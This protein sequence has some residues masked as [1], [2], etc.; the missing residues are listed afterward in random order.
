M[1][2]K[3]VAENWSNLFRILHLTAWRDVRNRPIVDFP[4]NE[5]HRH[6]SNIE[7]QHEIHTSFF[8]RVIWQ[9]SREE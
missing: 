8:S 2:A 4:I 1:P 9:V 5:I 6:R 3:G 7:F